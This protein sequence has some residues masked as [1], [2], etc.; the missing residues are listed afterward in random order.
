MFQIRKFTKATLLL[1]AVILFCT[2][3]HV[4]LATKEDWIT[5]TPDKSAAVTGTAESTPTAT[6]GATAETFGVPDSEK[7]TPATVPTELP[8][9][10]PGGSAVTVPFH[11]VAPTPM[12]TAK[13]VPKS[14]VKPAVRNTDAPTPAATP[15][16]KQQ[17]TVS[18]KGPEGIF[19]PA[20]QLQY[21]QNV[22]KTVFDVTI[23]LCKSREIAVVYSG[24]VKRN[25]IYIEGIGDFH[26]D[27]PGGSRG[28]I[29]YV[30]GTFPSI[31]VSSYVL[32]DGD[33]IEWQYTR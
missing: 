12:P 27:G 23:D 28:W 32:K 5:A 26:C 22:T 9:A 13:T 1:A 6:P 8:T 30:N 16:P 4:R 20:T 29:Y 18:I 7:S 2:G 17:F 3:C 31:S 19:V 10:A 33:I 24:S 21:E 14:T 25:N 15:V 11:T